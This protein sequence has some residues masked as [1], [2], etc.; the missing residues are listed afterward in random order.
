MS[1]TNN[2]NKCENNN[3]VQGSEE[4]RVRGMK[5]KEET[6]NKKGAA[7]SL[8]LGCDWAEAEAGVREGVREGAREVGREGGR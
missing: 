3:A 5:S 1:V 4:R 8:V 6:P 2:G 7:S